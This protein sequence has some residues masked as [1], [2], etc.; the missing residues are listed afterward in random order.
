[1]RFLRVW[2]R[3]LIVYRENWKISFIPPALEPFFYLLAFGVGLSALVGTVHYEGSEISYLVFIAPALIAI[4]IM[5]NAFFENTYA[6]FVRM[7]YQKTFDAMM[8]TPLSL[9]EIIT[10]E[11]VWG[12]TKSVVATVI[13]LAVISLFGLIRYPSGLLIIPLSFIGGIAFGSI[14]M[15]FTAIVSNIE[16]FN[17]P[18]FLF[19]TP[20]FL[21]SG[22]FFPLETMPG[23]AQDIAFI[24][25]LTHIVNLTRSL[26]LGIVDASLLPGLCYFVIACFIFFPLAI[27]KMHRRLIK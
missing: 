19:I 13:M 12:A 18:V 22:T 11:I 16:L 8:A 14:G 25:P 10:G 9:Q 23:W 3:N 26:S 7:Y 20:M 2:Q 6:S 15:Y 4:N 5:N 1:M 21:F 17:L 24:M 27:H